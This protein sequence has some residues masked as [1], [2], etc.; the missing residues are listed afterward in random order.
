VR[1]E[2]REVVAVQRADR[3]DRGQGLEGLVVTGVA[4]LAQPRERQADAR[5]TVPERLP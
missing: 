4:P 3:V 1:L 2:L 5:L